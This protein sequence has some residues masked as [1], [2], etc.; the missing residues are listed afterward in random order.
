M[1]V[2]DGHVD[3][4]QVVLLLGASLPLP[5]VRPGDDDDQLGGQKEGASNDES[6]GVHA[7]VGQ[8]LLDE[9]F[10][11]VIA[12]AVPQIRHEIVGVPLLFQ[13]LQSADAGSVKGQ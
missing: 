1:E 3:H 12:T 8:F 13:F 6:E 7:A 5:D 10:G 4:G 9:D 11:H 2:V